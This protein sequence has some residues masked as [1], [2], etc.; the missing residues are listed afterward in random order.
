MAFVLGTLED[1]N[2]RVRPIA[3]C[4][5]VL[6]AAPAYLASHPH[7][8]TGRDLLDQRHACL[9]HRYPGAREFVW[10]LSTPDGP[11]RFEVQG[12][13]ESDDGDVLTAWA[14][15]GRG[16]VLKPAFEIADHL[17]SGALVPVVRGHPAAPGQ[18]R[19][20]LPAQAPAGPEEP[21][22]HRLHGRRREEGPRRNPRRRLTAPPHRPPHARAAKALLPDLPSQ[23]G[24]RQPCAC[25]RSRPP[26]A[27]WREAAPAQ[28]CRL[29]IPADGAARATSPSGI[30]LRADRTGRGNASPDRSGGRR[31]GP[32]GA[33]PSLAR[34]PRA[35]DP[36][37]RRVLRPRPG[38]VIRRETTRDGYILHFTGREAT[39]GILDRVLDEIEAS[40]SKRLR[41]R[42]LRL[43]L[44]IPIHCA[45]WPM[46]YALYPVRCDP[47]HP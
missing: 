30:R 41:G 7:P 31:R 15:A 22:L 44:P 36:R 9:L 21:P 2:F 20:R 34:H 25:R 46:P 14:L 45:G 47:R 28:G 4:P 26:R 39:C 32:R 16:I 23:I 10:T 17:A 42:V 27:G 35:R 40:L 38:L 8:R 43:K 12:P 24:T 5:R 11:Q 33:R 37:P 13:L 3:D 1:S 19:L 6:A 29:P 18:P